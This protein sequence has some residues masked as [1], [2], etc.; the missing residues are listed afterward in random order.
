MLVFFYRY[1]SGKM[2][3]F[4]L[5]F[6]QPVYLLLD[7]KTNSGTLK[8]CEHSPYECLPATCQCCQMLPSV[9]INIVDMSDNTKRSYINVAIDSKLL[10]EPITRDMLSH[11]PYTPESAESRSPL[12]LS[13]DETMKNRR[14][15]VSPEQLKTRL[16]SILKSEQRKYP[17]TRSVSENVYVNGGNDSSSYFFRTRALS[18]VPKIRK[19]RLISTNSISSV[20][21][22]QS[23]HSSSD[24]EW[25]EYDEHDVIK[26][27]SAISDEMIVG[28]AH[29][30]T[31]TLNKK[32]NKLNCCSVM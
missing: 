10:H 23:H 15:S 7:L 3:S 12:P 16:E 18:E 27:D 1:I 14:D 4:H 31:K 9:T 29:N 28:E 2:L 21:R 6:F 8:C 17:M 13:N 25:F 32:R 26:Q 22:L 30:N 19:M 11:D 5:F 24:E 20:Q